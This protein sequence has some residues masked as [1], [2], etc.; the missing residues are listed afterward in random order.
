[1]SSSY[2]D[3]ENPVLMVK[4][5]KLIMKAGLVSPVALVLPMNLYGGHTYRLYF[6]ATGEFT[7]SGTFGGN[8]VSNSFSSPDGVYKTDYVDI[9]IPG[10]LVCQ[11]SL[12]E[13][14]TLS[15]VND[16]TFEW[17]QLVEITE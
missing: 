16:V 15:Y 4:E 8:T 9:T 3:N 10:N 12:V 2:P 6:S 5:G 11:G 7:Y 17:Y 1:M 13:F 14:R